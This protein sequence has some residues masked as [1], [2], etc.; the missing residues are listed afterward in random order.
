MHRKHFW[1]R[2]GLIISEKL[3]ICFVQMKCSGRNNPLSRQHLSPLLFQKDIRDFLLHN[4]QNNIQEIHKS[5]HKSVITCPWKQ[6]S[7]EIFNPSIF[8]SPFSPLKRLDPRYLLQL[9]NQLKFLQF[10]FHMCNQVC[11]VTDRDEYIAY[12]QRMTFRHTLL[13]FRMSLNGSTYT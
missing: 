11:F 4:L 10:I 8:N 6:F 2:V 3:Y 9:F 1:I 7:F 13:N 5:K 12:Y